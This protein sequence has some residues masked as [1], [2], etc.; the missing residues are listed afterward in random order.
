MSA[1]QNLPYPR[2]RPMTDADLPQVIKVEHASYEFPWTPGI[3]RDCVRVGYYCYVLEGPSGL[4]GHG[5]MSI[6]VGECHLL[7]ICVHPDWQHRGFGRHIV[8]FLLDVAR[9]KRAHMA[10]LEVRVSN[11]IAHKL[12]TDLGFNEVGMRHHYYP[13]PQGRED[14]IILAREL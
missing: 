8:K 13:G 3:F 14:A 9:E 5:I 11:A 1:V 4:I 2:L 12:Y 7:N 6:A 10:L